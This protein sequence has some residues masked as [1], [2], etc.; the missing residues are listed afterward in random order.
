MLRVLRRSVAAIAWPIVRRRPGRRQL[1]D[2]SHLH[3]TLCASRKRL[4][5]IREVRH[6]LALRPHLEPALIAVLFS[7]QTKL[8]AGRPDKAVLNTFREAAK[9]PM[10]VGDALVPLV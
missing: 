6:V 2:T 9:W 5:V 10:S 7:Y 4:N 1:E 8:G 3:G